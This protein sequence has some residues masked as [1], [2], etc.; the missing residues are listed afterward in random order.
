MLSQGSPSRFQNLKPSTHPATHPH[1]TGPEVV[2]ILDRCVCVCVCVCV[3]AREGIN[4]HFVPRI[5]V[6]QSAI[7]SK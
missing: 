4:Y 3:C 7:L 5:K 6:M 1:Q 2:H